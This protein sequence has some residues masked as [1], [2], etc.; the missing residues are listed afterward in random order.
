MDLSAI[1]FF[2]IRREDYPRYLS[3]CVDA[4]NLPPTHEKWL[5]AANKGVERLSR[6]GIEVF[7]VEVDLDEFVAW[8]RTKGLN[9]DSEARTSYANEIAATQLRARSER[10][11]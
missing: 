4:A 7:R 3:L 11:H 8:C 5:Y 9:V 6:A 2:W 1:A 10:K